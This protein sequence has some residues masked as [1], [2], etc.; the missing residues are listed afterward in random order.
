MAR[1]RLYIPGGIYDAEGASRALLAHSLSGNDVPLDLFLTARTIEFLG[2]TAGWADVHHGTLRVHRLPGDH[3][4]LF[5]PSY[6]E[7]IA[8][9]LASSIAQAVADQT[10]RAR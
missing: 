1:R 8:G 3:K 9:S 4:S 6:A 2:P 7:T 10:E 5:G